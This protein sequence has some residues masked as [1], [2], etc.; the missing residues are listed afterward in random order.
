[1]TGP[2]RKSVALLTPS[3]GKD[4]ERFALLCDSIDRHVTGFERHYVLVRD[5]EVPLFSRFAG[6]RRIVLPSSH[7]LPS[8]LRLAPGVRLKHGRR[9]WW[10]L[11]AG[12]VHGWHIQQLLKCAAASRLPQERYCIIDSDNA[13]FRPFD[14]GAYAGGARTPLYVDRK[15]IASDAPLHAVW[16]RNCD[17]LLGNPQTS[18][19]A[20]DYIGQ[21]IVW[22][23]S[24]VRDMTRAIERATGMEWAQ[25]LCKTR[26]F[27]EYL[28]YG[29]FV[30]N[31]PAHLAGH[32]LTGESI[33]VAY[34]DAAPLD[35][36]AIRSLLDA[37]PGSKAALSVASFSGT[38]MSAIREAAGLSQR[39]GAALARAA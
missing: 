7:Y 32:E 30:R 38:P 5:S 17:R 3:Y 4:I 33:A 19:P 29:H 6:P 21:D 36:A 20:D 1:M 35:A 22:D 23:K 13:F 8:W 18:F 24:T 26:A 28:L 2:E 14:V 16:T 25:A 37:A 11:R 27:S 9:V 15:A 31:S 12:L 39:D 10:S 34:W